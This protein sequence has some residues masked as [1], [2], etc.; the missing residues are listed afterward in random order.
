MGGNIGIGTAAP[1][2]KLQVHS[3]NPL[4]GD[5]QLFS[6]TADFE[7]DGGGDGLFVFKDTGGRTAFLGGRIGVGTIAPQGKLHVHSDNPLQGDA[8]LF[9]GAA[10]FEYDGGNDGLFIFKDT[11]GRTAFMGGNVGFG[12]LNPAARVEIVGDVLLNGDAFVSFGGIWTTSDREEKAEIEPIH[13]ALDQVLALQGLSFKW[14]DAAARGAPR[15]REL[16]FVAQDVEAVFPQ[17]VKETPRGTKAV[18]M[19]GLNALLVEAA[20]ELASR[21]ERLET[22]VAKLRAT[23]EG[24]SPTTP[25]SSRPRR[26]RKKTT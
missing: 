26:S 8:Q 5:I 3:A 22:E 15:E 11:G 13:R 7:Y 18:N 25:K 6:G 14:R 21:C 19:T 24:P 12:T 2:A 9:S 20:R 10:D 23:A 17:W 4:Q 16:G 1:T